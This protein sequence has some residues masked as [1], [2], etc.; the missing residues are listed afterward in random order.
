MTANLGAPTQ[1]RWRRGD[2]ALLAVLSGAMLLDAIEVSM[3][4]VALPSIG[5]DLDAGVPG[6]FWTMSGFALG[7]GGLLLL[8]G[9][10]VAVAGPRRA[11]LAALLIFALA[12]LVS[13]VVTDPAT[14]AAARFVKGLS[15]ALTAPTGLAIIAGRF[16]PPLRPRAVAVYTSAGAAG[17]TAGLLFAGVL[18]PLGWRVTL[19]FPAV[20]ALLLF[21]LA[22]HL[23]PRDNSRL[24]LLP[25]DR[26]G[27]AA[28]VALLTGPA[29]LAFAVVH[30]AGGGAAPGTVLAGALAALLAVVFVRAERRSSSPLVRLPARGRG[31]LVRATAGAAA[32]NGAFW[33]FLFIC[34]LHLQD[35]AGWS[36]WQCA[37]ALLPMGLL[38]VCAVPFSARLARR[39]GAHTLV[40]TGSVLLPPAYLLYRP[41]AQPDYP[42]GI[43]PTVLLVGT[44]FALAFPALHLRATSGLDAADHGAAGALYQTAVQLGGTTVLA[45]VAAVMVSAV[46]AG[47]PP[48]VAA[49]AG[50][51]SA[52]LLITAVAV[53]GLAAALAPDRQPPT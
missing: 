41:E 31:G 33:G 14:I 30:G 18:T 3:T 40:V 49:T 37:A 47:A 48:G 51:Q 21:P 17:F 15:A 2:L 50:A 8:G 46:P 39:F 29:A 5:H 35:A 4:M 13:S 26:P 10:I 43:L 19:L 1:A 34:T 6:L 52:L 42:A 45:V 7:F 23:L 16:E 9:Q 32:M 24:R 27:T 38:L 44:G 11:Y 12:S 53:A 22:A 36:A 25:R 20:A 28:A